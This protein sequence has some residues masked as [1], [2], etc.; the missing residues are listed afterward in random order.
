MGKAQAVLDLFPSPYAMREPRKL[1][2]A[3][4]EALAHPLEEADTHL[5]RIQR[6]HRLEVAEHAED[7]LE[8]A[9]VLGLERRHFDDLLESDEIPY[10]DK[11]R[12]MRRRVRRVARLHLEGAGTPW[13]VVEAAAIFL[14]ADL[15]PASE[16]RRGLRTIDP[17]GFAHRADLRSD[18]IDGGVVRPLYL[19]E[20][21][22]RRRKVAPADRW[23]LLGWTLENQSVTRV[24]VR[25]SI[26]GVND[27]T[28]RPAVLC[29]D[30]RQGIRFD[31]VVP[32]GSTLV[33]DHRG[34]RLDG[35]AVDE[36]MTFFEGGIHD[37]ADAGN[38][39]AV[40]Q[41]AATAPAPLDPGRRRVAGS[42]IR[43]PRPVPEAPVGRSGW[44]LQVAEGVYDGSELDYAV[45]ETP[46]LPVG[47]F[48][49][50][51]GFESAV[52]YYPPSAV[53]GMAWEERI[54]CAFKLALP[55][56]FGR[57]PRLGEPA[58]IW[59]LGEGTLPPS[60]TAPAEGE[61]GE[62]RLAPEAH[63]RME[64]AVAGRVASLLP[65]F[66]AAGIRAFVEPAPNAWRLGAATLRAFTARRGDGIASDATVLSDPYRDTLVRV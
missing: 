36:W 16:D 35:V 51:P 44:L 13:A 17:E 26:R 56:G 28:V 15:A 66:K 6:A 40:S 22:R 54:P 9:A 7:I 29:P 65:R 27:R 55:R 11:L 49:A 25:L 12:L 50:D 8:L 43:R 64:R 3:V 20:N 2:R 4:V 41:T 58:D 52:F 34:A 60:G 48:D 10:A 45:F 53:V 37:Y 18:A 33:I 42:P 46:H 24:G 61:L 57:A 19:D 62:T 38:A 5:F 39:T 30:G 21:P 59:T 31:G 23:P 47:H 32:D 1:V 14:D 63:G